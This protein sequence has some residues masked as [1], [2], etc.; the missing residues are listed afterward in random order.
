MLEL[1]YFFRIILFCCK[2]IFPMLLNIFHH[3]INVYSLQKRVCILLPQCNFLA[4]LSRR[5]T[6]HSPDAD[7]LSWREPRK[8]LWNKEKVILLT[9]IIFLLHYGLFVKRFSNFLW[10]LRLGFGSP[11]LFVDLPTFWWKTMRSP[12]AD[13]LSWREK[14]KGL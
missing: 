4:A 12:D 3:R 6:M 14:R 2:L 9:G 7:V 5:K 1:S 13:A 10:K 11:T 8:G